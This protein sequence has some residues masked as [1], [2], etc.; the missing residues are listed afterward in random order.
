MKKIILCLTIAVVFVFEAEVYAQVKQTGAQILRTARS[1]YDQG[2]LHELPTFLEDHLNAH[3]FQSDV[4]TVEAYKILVLTYIYLEEPE[5]A[6]AAMQH[7]LETDNFF[8]PNL[9]DPIEFKNLYGKFQSDPVFKFGLKVGGNFT[10]V[11]TIAVHYIPSQ[12]QGFGKY[13]PNFGFNII[14]TFEKRIKATQIILN[15]ELNFV[16]QSFTYSNESVF[17]DDR[18]LSSNG[19]SEVTSETAIIEN[20]ISHTRLQINALVQYEFAKPNGKEYKNIPFIPYVTVGPSAGYLLSSTFDGLVTFED[21][22]EVAGAIDNKENYKPINLS[23]IA[24]AGAKLKM[25]PILLNADFRL[26]IGLF[27]IV[28]ENNRSKNTPVNN[29]LRSDFMYTNND[30]SVR[31]AMFNVGIIYPFFQPKKLIK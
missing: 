22:F 16:T 29:R 3:D 2:R 4:E 19:D 12:S 1:I 27:N 18:D 9:S 13:T 20:R 6:D 30:F 26:Q 25:G 17:F 31:Q 10:E 21:R 14:G 8:E 24:G 23:V 5:K 11:N 15:P 7:I 28:D